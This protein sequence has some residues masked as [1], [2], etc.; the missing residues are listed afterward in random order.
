MYKK[1][2]FLKIKI[3]KS[4]SSSYKNISW[5]YEGIVINWEYFL[6]SLKK[7]SN[8]VSHST[9]IIKIKNSFI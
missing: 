8:N 4:N 5:L 7:I 2:K 3:K 1:H 9:F 6:V